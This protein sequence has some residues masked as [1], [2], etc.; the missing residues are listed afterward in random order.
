MCKPVSAIWSVK[1]KDN[2]CSMLWRGLF[3]E[4]VTKEKS[5]DKT[6]MHSF[7]LIFL[8]LTRGIG[9]G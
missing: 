7:V 2:I 1:F 4:I 5:K 9:E 8:T 6:Q 3:S